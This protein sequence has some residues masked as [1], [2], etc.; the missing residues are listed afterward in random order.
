MVKGKTKSGFAYSID[1]AVT[2]DMLFIESL[3]K[4]DKGDLMALSSILVT[5]L[6]EKQKEKL[7]EHVKDKDG[8]VP[9][10]KTVAEVTDILSG[11]GETL[12]N[13][14]TSQPA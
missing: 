9:I 7:Y 2:N 8:H 4:A 3:A 6:G 1:E 10:D 12:K 13:S 5:L 14:R 11:A